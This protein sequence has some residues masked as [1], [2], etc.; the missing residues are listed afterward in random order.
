MLKGLRKKY[1]VNEKQTN[2]L[3]QPTLL[4]AQGVSP[5]NGFGK[6]Q[7]LDDT[8]FKRKASAASTA[9]VGDKQHLMKNKK[10]QQDATLLT[11]ELLENPEV[12]KSPLITKRSVAKGCH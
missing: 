12:K 2:G 8:V 1:S 5:Q 9:Q 6:A 3:K 7:N 10:K 4:P 11:P